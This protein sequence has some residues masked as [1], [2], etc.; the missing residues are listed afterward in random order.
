MISGIQLF[1]EAGA[2]FGKR[3]EVHNAEVPYSNLETTHF[4]HRFEFCG[5]VAVL[6]FNTH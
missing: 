1:D 2:L 5:Q 3:I 6:I 4:V